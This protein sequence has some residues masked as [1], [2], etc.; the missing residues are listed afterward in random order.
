M[1]LR[2]F[3]RYSCVVI[4][5]VL[6]CKHDDT[7]APVNNNV[8]TPITSAQAAQA[9]ARGVNLTNWFN[10]YS[11]PA[12]FDN[13]FTAAD[14]QRIKAE[15]FTYIRLPIGSPWLFSET[16]SGN[17]TEG[18]VKKVDAAVKIAIDAGLAV[19]LDPLHNSTDALEIK[20]AS[21]AGY[22]DK[23]A[24]YWKSL[25]SYFSKYETDKIFFEVYNEPHVASSGALH[26]TKAWWWPIQLK[27]IQAIRSVTLNHYIIA[28]AES[29]N[30]RDQLVLNTP[31][32][33]TNVIY[34]F[35]FYDPF[36]FT[37]QGADWVGGGAVQEARGVPFPSTPANVDS[38]V[39]AT[40]YQDLKDQ[41]TWYGSQKYNI[42]SLARWVKPAAD[43]GKR[44]N[45]V[46]TCN[47]FGSYKLYSPRASRLQWVHDIRTVLEQA[48]V[49]WA[50]WEYDEGF[51]LINYTNNNRSQAVE[52]T[53]MLVSLGLR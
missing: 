47:E 50:M 24:S 53:D 6:S 41:L 46:V 44:N 27:F 32:N 9:L 7:P 39:K 13:R 4:L 42:D 40:P 48:G 38:L 22:T 23:I 2:F 37:H 43:W 36:L 18:N 45:V 25:A 34:N 3:Y 28:G 1:G 33:E 49:P 14:M 19:V 15:G 21:A 8:G 31:Y 10:D 29:W 26:I 52:D 20:L 5:I 16:A 12:Q 30:S 11:D 35:H 51:G 17:V